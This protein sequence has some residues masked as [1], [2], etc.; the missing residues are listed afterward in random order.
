[1]GV[2]ERS[3]GTRRLPRSWKSIMTFADFGS[4]TT[5]SASITSS[6]GIRWVIMLAAHSRM[7][8]SAATTSGISV[9]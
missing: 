5:P 1:M 7:P 2:E 6:K 9:G 3:G 4:A 8:G